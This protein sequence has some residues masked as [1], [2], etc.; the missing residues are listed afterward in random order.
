MTGGSA[1]IRSTRKSPL[2]M[3]YT[4]ILLLAVL[5]GSAY[6]AT[7][8]SDRIALKI[9]A[10]ND[11]HGWLQPSPER[12]RIMGP[13]APLESA[14]TAGGMPQLAAM[15]DRFRKQSGNFAFVS[16]GDLFGASPLLSAMFDNE[17]TIEA[18]NAA[19]LDFNGV[20]NHEFDRGVADLR[21]MQAGGCPPNGC[22]SGASFGGARFPFLSAN[23]VL[24][25]TGRTLFPPYGIKEYDGVKVAF[26][27]LTLR[28]TGTILSQRARAGIEFRDE[29]EAVKQYLPELRAKGVN[30][31][32][33]LIHQGGFNRGGANECV[34]FQGPIADVVARLDPAVDLVVSGHT[35]Q[36]YVCRLHERLVTSAGAFG[37]FVTEIDLELDRKT[38]RV[39]STTAVNHVV[40]PDMPASAKEA[41]LVE[42]YVD[43]SG[44]V[45]RPLG[46]IGATFSRAQN[47]DGE[48]K[49]GQFVADAHLAATKGVG[50][51]VAFMNS[52]GI[53]AP[54]PFKD[55]G[56]VT[57]A[58]VY[59]VFPFD[60]TL[61]TI[62]LTGA[63]LLETLEQQWIGDYP[64]VLAVS[65]GFTYTWDPKA[66]AGQR[67]VSGSV[68]I[69]DAPLEPTRGYLI[70]VNSFLAGG[71]DRF[72]VFK[73]GEPRISGGSSR[74]AI[75]EYLETRSPVIP[76]E[77]R[78]IRRADEKPR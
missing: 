15:I 14:V 57:F 73:Q 53:R 22:K 61:V 62:T 35:H 40:L 75:V 27:G 69:D 50:A 49:L 78:R 7:P 1:I 47:S 28:A 44:R 77:E 20:G 8:A 60:D 9:A 51:T 58:D 25:E 56:A 2:I 34:D 11:F 74:Q 3:R 43:L 29:A 18:M 38:G 70:T 10:I 55:G 48:S 67:V 68:K 24:T 13:Q 6:A 65:Q 36:A 66:P 63:E 23:V 16:A 71:G 17:P 5:H 19:G 41:A 52:G 76:S 45:Q 31:I 21:R 39:L 37:R 42:R 30:A 59:S 54:L 12:V 64:R 72:D 32:V 33:V 4:V 26:I 46:Y